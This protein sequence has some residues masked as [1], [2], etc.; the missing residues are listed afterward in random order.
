MRHQAVTVSW[1]PGSLRLCPECGAC[2]QKELGEPIKEL[3]LEDDIPRGA[4][5]PLGGLKAVCCVQ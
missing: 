2:P 5:D 1:C 3:S 4:Q